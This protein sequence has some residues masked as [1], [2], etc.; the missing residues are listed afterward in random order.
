MSRANGLTNTLRTILRSA[1]VPLTAA[2]L[3]ER[4]RDLEQPFVDNGFTGILAQRVKAGEFIGGQRDDRA[5]FL[6]NAEYRPYAKQIAAY[7]A[8]RTRKEQREA[9]LP[10]VVSVR[11][12]Y[13][14]R[15][16]RL[17]ALCPG[18]RTHAEEQAIAALAGVMYGTEGA[19]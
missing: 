12:L 7:R 15:V 5:T 1:R 10:G 11:Q 2:Q 9:R 6:L 17:A 16:V 18:K 19:I 8:N 3:R 14:R 4:L 13:L